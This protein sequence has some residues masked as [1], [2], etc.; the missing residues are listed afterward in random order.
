[1]GTYSIAGS[2]D[3][4]ANITLRGDSLGTNIV[5]SA[6]TFSLFRMRN[7]SEIRNLKLTGADR[8]VSTSIA[9]EIGG[10][11]DY[12]NLQCKIRDIRLS[13]GWYYGVYSVYEWIIPD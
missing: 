11:T 5:A 10:D 13:T 3:L 8:T 12:V 2:I 4:Y 6:A 7:D 1:V 9:I